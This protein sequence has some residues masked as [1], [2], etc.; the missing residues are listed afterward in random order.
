LFDSP[1]S[2][3]KNSRPAIAYSSKK[4]QHSSMPTGGVQEGSIK[5]KMQSAQRSASAAQCHGQT[6]GMPLSR[7]TRVSTRV[8]PMRLLLHQDLHTSTH[9]NYM[10]SCATC[11]TRPIGFAPV[12]VMHMLVGAVLAWQGQMLVRLTWGIDPTQALLLLGV[13][14]SRGRISWRSA[15]GTEWD[16]S[17]RRPGVQ[18]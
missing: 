5:C 9:L 4:T 2:A 15:F 16:R 8:C 7:S 17:N 14:I 11:A 6:S 18:P 10:L 12:Q 1:V 3:I 13:G